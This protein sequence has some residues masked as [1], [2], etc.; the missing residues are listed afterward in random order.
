[1]SGNKSNKATTF[2]E[3]KF[4]PAAVKIGSQRHLLALRDG[5]IMIMP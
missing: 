4:L 3:E 5:I 2:M 1:M